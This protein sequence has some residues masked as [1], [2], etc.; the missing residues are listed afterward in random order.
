M[1]W[2]LDDYV[3]PNIM[4]TYIRTALSYN[5]DLDDNYQKYI[6]IERP[7]FS[8]YT[9]WAAG[10]HIDQQ[11]RRETELDSNNIETLQ[12]YKFN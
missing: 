9:R 10:V 12:N 3:V 4:N 2:E 7:F 8:P 5:I 6:D 1:D 11:F